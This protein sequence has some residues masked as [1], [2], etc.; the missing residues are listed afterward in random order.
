MLIA[1]GAMEGLTYYLVHFLPSGSSVPAPISIRNRTKDEDKRFNEERIRNES[2]LKRV[3]IYAARAIQTQDQT[4]LN[5]YALVKGRTN[6]FDRLP[7]APLFLLAA[8]ELFAQ[9]STLFTD[10]L[11]EDYP[12][13]LRCIRA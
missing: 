7:T 9:H 5:R 13:I 10:Y 1:A 8:L 2:D 11:Y 3:Y 12:D 4:N 6:D